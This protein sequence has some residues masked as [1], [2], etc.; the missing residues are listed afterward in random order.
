MGEGTI[1]V[2][3][4]K[5]RSFA[6][7][8]DKV[9]NG[10]KESCYGAK[11]QIDSLKNIW[12]GEAAQTYQTSFQKLMDECNEALTVLGKMVNSLYDSADRYDKTMKSVKDD[13]KNIP[14]LP[15]N[16]FK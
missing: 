2:D 10:L 6:E 12:T 11:S 14:K 13:V 7:S 1:Q 16:L 9:Q 3:A 8:I 4:A 5:L 15:T